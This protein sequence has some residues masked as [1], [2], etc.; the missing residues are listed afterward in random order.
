MSQLSSHKLSQSCRLDFDENK[1][2]AHVRQNI[3]DEKLE[4]DD[5]STPVCIFKVPKILL[6]YI[7]DLC[8]PQQVSIGP[9]HYLHQGLD[10]MERFKLSAAKRARKRLH[11]S[12]FEQLV[13]QL[14]KLEMKIRACYNNFLDF[15]SETLA[16]MMAIDA[17]FMLE[18]ME[19]YGL[20]KGFSMMRQLRG[21]QQLADCIMV[22]DLVMLENQI[23]L[24]VLR[25]VLEFQQPFDKVDEKLISVMMNF[26]KQLSPLSLTDNNLSARSFHLLGFLYEAITATF[27]EIV[28]VQEEDDLI[29]YV[30]ETADQ[31]HS[32][33]A[34]TVTIRTCKL[35]SIVHGYVVCLARKI[36]I[37]R[38]ANVMTML[39]WKIVSNLPIVSMVKQPIEEYFL[40]NEENNQSSENG[41]S[42]IDEIPIPSVTEL[43]DSGICFLP[44]NGGISSISFDIKRKI[45]YLPKVDIDMHTEVV[46]RNLVSYETLV[47]EGPMV[48]TRYTELMNGIID[49][50]EDVRLLKEFGIIRNHLKSDCEVTN[51]WNGMMRKSSIRLTKVVFLDKMI[52]Q[53]NEYYN[54]RWRA[55]LQ[56]FAT[57]YVFDPWKFLVCLGVIFFLLFMMIQ[58]ICSIYK[59]TKLS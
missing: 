33:V 53:V 54:S 26:C 17:C 59:F 15:K 36:P 37:S 3:N 31:D 6:S 29:D 35:I 56:H 18:F 16:W 47:V 1:W 7:P 34:K 19:T 45:I 40:S 43:I 55:K 50:D 24:F 39:S 23:P 5:S 4:E 57:F 13:E 22:Q 41:P 49:T 21:G 44:T 27:D 11:C 9:Y 20:Q 32:S 30:S 14:D 12:K 52:E 10:E 8:L 25:K 58:A 42:L 28:Q 38:L 2:I 51:L 46:L 48:L